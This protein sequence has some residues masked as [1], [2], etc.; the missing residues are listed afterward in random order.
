MTFISKDELRARFCT[1]LSV[2]Y[3]TEVPLY[4]DL[5]ELVDDVNATF[6]GTPEDRLKVERHGAIRLGKPDELQMIARLFAQMGMEPVGYY[7][8]APSGVPVH[9]T[10]F[11]PTTEEALAYNPFRVFTSLLLP[12][13]LPPALRAEVEATLAKR[14]IFHIR[15]RE[16]VAQAEVEGGVRLEDADELVERAL[17]TFKWHD[18]AA[19]PRDVYARMHAAHPLV[20]DIAA[21]KGPHINHLTPRVL[22]IDAA[23]AGMSARGITPKQIIEGPPKRACE[24]LLRQTSF[25]ALTERIKFAG[26]ASAGSHRARFGEIEQRGCALTKKGHNLYLQLLATVPPSI[27]NEE[28][29]ANLAAAFKSFPDSYEEMFAQG[30]GYFEF[31]LAGS[32]PT[33]PQTLEQLVASGTVKLSPVTYEDFL[34]ASAAGIFQSN[35]DEHNRSRGG[36]P[37]AQG[38]TR[39]KFAA[40]LPVD[41]RDSF[42][43]H[44]GIQKRSL[45]A[46]EAKLGF[47]LE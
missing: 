25:Q 27:N 42:E 12:E 8:L 46:L 24:I 36:S 21:F 32:A 20:A 40:L 18:T 17:E 1:A 29:Q 15:V 37:S 35:L 43:L 5:I 22:D 38:W 44:E 39:E 14:D 31:S 26:E 16:I 11:R 10:A 4:G 13:L 9:S 3:R 34:P 28:H 23:Q 19:V 7:V 30:L 2:M 47:K 6:P 33:S 41:M 45:E